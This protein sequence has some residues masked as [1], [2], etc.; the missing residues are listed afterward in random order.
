MKQSIGIA[1]YEINKA[2]PKEIRTELPTI[3]EI[4]LATTKLKIYNG[5]RLNSMVSDYL[6]RIFFLRKII[7]IFIHYKS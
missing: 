5:F 1:E 7:L 3:E 2:I 4:E 6:Q